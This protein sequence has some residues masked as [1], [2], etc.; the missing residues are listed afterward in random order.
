MLKKGIIWVVE[1]SP[2]GGERV[3]EASSPPIT[4]PYCASPGS[5]IPERRQG[6]ISL[7]DDGRCDRGLTISPSLVATFGR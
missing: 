4:C 2:T 3:R 6:S 7:Q 1:R 5:A